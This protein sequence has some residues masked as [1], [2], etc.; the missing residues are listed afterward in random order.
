M[1]SGFAPILAL[2]FAIALDGIFGV[3]AFAATA[4][5]AGQ[6]AAEFALVM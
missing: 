5:L 6:A 2:A 1:S 3:I 4:T